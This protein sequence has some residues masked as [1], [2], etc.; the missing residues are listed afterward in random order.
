MI[1]VFCNLSLVSPCTVSIIK[2]GCFSCKM[3][4]S[5][6]FAGQFKFD[7]PKQMLGLLREYAGTLEHLV[8]GDVNG[9]KKFCFI[10]RC[11]K[12]NF[13][14]VSVVFLHFVISY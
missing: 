9:L 3:S 5:V 13:S 8:V 1:F 4:L 14:I 6:L 10:Y 2:Y 7:V 11:F 12:S